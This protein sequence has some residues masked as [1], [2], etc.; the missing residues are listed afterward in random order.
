MPAIPKSSYDLG[1]FQFNVE[2]CI[3]M[4]SG[5]YH[6]RI[7]WIDATLSAKSLTDLQRVPW[8]LTSLDMKL[9]MACVALAR[10]VILVNALRDAG[11][12]LCANGSEMANGRQCLWI[13]YKYFA[14]PNDGDAD[15]GLSP[16]YSVLELQLIKL[17]GGDEGLERYC[18]QWITTIAKIPGEGGPRSVFQH[19]F[20]DEMRLA[21]LMES[22]VLI[23]DE[24]DAGADKNTW[25]WLLKKGQASFQRERERDNLL[26][27]QKALRGLNPPK[28]TTGGRKPHFETALPAYDIPREGE[29]PNPQ[30]AKNGKIQPAANDTT[31]QTPRGKCWY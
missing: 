27:K 8:K 15:R 1:D 19:L 9:S 2:I 26:R 6:L 17:Q 20:V 29:Q 22:Y 23:Y 3:I 11:S 16:N 14:S 12:Q 31:E 25:E 10:N 18:A 28:T 4:A 24:A 5:R 13:I 30:Q 7:E 21:P